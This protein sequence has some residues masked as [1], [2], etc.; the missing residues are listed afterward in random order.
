LK[1]RGDTFLEV[2][3]SDGSLDLSNN[4]TGSGDFGGGSYSIFWSNFNSK[5][6]SKLADLAESYT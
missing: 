6:Y 3:I 2:P 1:E 5:V 4:W